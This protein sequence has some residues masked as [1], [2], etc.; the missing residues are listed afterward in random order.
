MGRLAIV[1]PSHKRAG[2]VRVKNVI[3]D[4]IVC[5]AE[6]QVPE[7]RE[8]NPDVEVLGHPSD[9]IGLPLKRNWIAERFGDVFMVDDDVFQFR[10]YTPEAG[11]G[12]SVTPIEARDHIER[13]SDMTRDSGSFLFGFTSAIRPLYYKPQKPYALTGMISGHAMGLLKGS[14]LYWH[15]KATTVCD[16]WL[17][18]LNAYHHRTIVKDLRYGFVPEPPF[19][20][21][22]GQAEHRSMAVEADMTK[23]LFTHFGS[24]NRQ[25]G[26]AGSKDTHE[27]MRILDLPF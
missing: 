19:V 7:Y 10:D 20:T 24:A 6:N 25:R 17:C 16:Q 21:P 13:L 26:G 2:H 15:S 8:H 12:R 1:S 5:V 18:A 27:A 4:V 3:S 22:G 9:I 23:F 11:G 14:K